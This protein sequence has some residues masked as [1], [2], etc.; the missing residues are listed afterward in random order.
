MKDYI[1]KWK[2]LKDNNRNF[3]EE[4]KSKLWQDYHFSSSKKY[5]FLYYDAKC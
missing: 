2:I 3:D 4:F 5:K 1:S